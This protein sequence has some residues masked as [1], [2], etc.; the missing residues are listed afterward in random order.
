MDAYSLIPSKDIADYCREIGYE[1]SPIEIAYLIKMNYNKMTIIEQNEYYQ[2]LIDTYPNVR[3]HESVQLLGETML[4]EYLKTLIKWNCDR[5]SLF[6]EIPERTSNRFV[7]ELSWYSCNRL[8]L[9][10]KQ[11]DTFEEVLHEVEPYW[12]KIHSISERNSHVRICRRRKR[13]TVSS[14]HT[15][16]FADVNEKGECIWLSGGEYLLGKGKRL[17]EALH[18][19]YVF[20]PVPFEPGDIVIMYDGTPAVLKSLPPRSLSGLSP[21]SYSHHPNANAPMYATVF[22]IT[23]DGKLADSHPGGKY[24]RLYNGWGIA[25]EE[26]KY[27]KGEFFG[28]YE[29]LPRLGEYIKEVG[30][31]K[32]T[33]MIEYSERRRPVDMKDY[34]DPKGFFNDVV[35]DLM[36]K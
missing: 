10:S 12:N 21:D 19:I 34:K 6:H 28:S 27:Y 16:M 1:L 2:E 5:I 11:Y 14:L 25:N 24:L 13:R 23:H 18:G 17:D 22:Y 31:E 20:L 9:P 15:S 4:H 29:M 30:V 35:H 8:E 7:F 36:N 3:F 32:F 26:L 33:E